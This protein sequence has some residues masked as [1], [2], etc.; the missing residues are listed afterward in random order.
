[1]KSQTSL[2]SKSAH[3]Q[4]TKRS[5]SWTSEP[6]TKSEIESLRQGKRYISAYVQKEFSAVVQPKLD[7]LKKQAV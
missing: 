3:S 7:R 1:M 4:P 5:T 6:L 2:A